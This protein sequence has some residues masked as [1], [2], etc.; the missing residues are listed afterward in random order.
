M[1]LT[2]RQIANMQNVGYL[3]TK[4]YS[5]QFRIKG[6]QEVKMV[7]EHELSYLFPIKVSETPVAKTLW[8][9]YE[10]INKRYEVLY[11]CKK[12]KGSIT[13]PMANWLSVYHLLKYW[14]HNSMELRQVINGLDQLVIAYNH[15]GILNE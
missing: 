12:A 6:V 11:Y 7:L 10:V 2:D 4:R 3:S 13:L 15:K 8:D 5:F 9:C 14:S 1:N